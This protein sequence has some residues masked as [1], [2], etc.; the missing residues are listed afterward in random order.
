MASHG[1][2]DGVGEESIV[3]KPRRDGDRIVRKE[4]HEKA[5]Q[6]RRKCGS[7]EDR[8]RVHPGIPQDLGI[9]K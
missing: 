1:K 8:P 4:S 6:N 3:T 2:D 5:A 9:H 7:R